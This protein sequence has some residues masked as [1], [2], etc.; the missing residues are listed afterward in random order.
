MIKISMIDFAKKTHGMRDDDYG[1]G[2]MIKLTGTPRKAFQNLRNL[3]GCA[4]WRNT[5]R[6]GRDN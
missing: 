4:N 6:D 5:L 1:R 3:G 2:N